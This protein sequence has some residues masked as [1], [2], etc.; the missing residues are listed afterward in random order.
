MRSTEAVIELYECPP[1]RARITTHQCALN[2]ECSARANSQRR[3]HKARG[4]TFGRRECADCPGVLAFAQKSGTTPMTLSER[5]LR[6]AHD[7]AEAL[8][9]RTCMIPERQTFSLRGEDL[10]SLLGRA[11]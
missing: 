10:A 9:R 2:R 1:L 7:A 5:A 8:R 6:G 3:L 11:F 4:D